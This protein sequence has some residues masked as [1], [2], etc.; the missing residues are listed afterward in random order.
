MAVDRRA[1]ASVFVLVGSLLAGPAAGAHQSAVVV[2]APACR[3]ELYPLTVKEVRARAD[4]RNA[5]L[6]ALSPHV[7]YADLAGQSR[8]EHAADPRTPLAFRQMSSGGLSAVAAPPASSPDPITLGLIEERYSFVQHVK[9]FWAG[10]E[11]TTAVYVSLPGAKI[12]S[13]GDYLIG[14][15]NKAVV[16]FLHGGATATSSGKAGVNIGEKMAPRGFATVAIDLF[17]HGLGT[18]DLTGLED[19]EKQINFVLTVLN[20]LIHPAVRRVGVGHSWGAQLYEYAHRHSDEAKYKN[21]DH[22]YILAP[23]V[24]ASNCGDLRV[25]ARLDAERAARL[26]SLRDQ[27]APTDKKFL[28]QWLT[29]GRDSEIGRIF[30]AATDRGYANPPLSIERQRQLKPATKIVSLGDGVTFVGYEE[31][32]R[33]AWGNLV[34]PSRYI[35]LGPGLTFDGV[36]PTGHGQFDLLDERGRF[37]VYGLI[38]DTLREITGYAPVDVDGMPNLLMGIHQNFPNLLDQP[39]GDVVPAGVTARLDK[40]REYL[41]DY[42]RIAALGGDARKSV[43]APYARAYGELMVVE[44]FARAYWNFPGFRTIIER[45]SQILFTSSVDTAEISGRK[46][47]LDKYQRA[48][49]DLRKTSAATTKKAVKTAVEELAVRLDL[50]ASFDT[51]RATEELNFPPLTD[52]RRAAL[53][54]LTKRAEDL[55]NEGDRSAEPQFKAD[56]E[57][58]ASRYETTLSALDVT[59]ATYAQARKTFGTGKNLDR[60]QNQLRVN[61]EH[62]HKD[63]QEAIKAREDRI[64]AREDAVLIPLAKRAGVANLTTARRELEANRSHDRR[65]A[66]VNF[67]TQKP[68]VVREVEA[69]ANDRLAEELAAV[70]R[71]AGADELSDFA[72]LQA[73]NDKLMRLA[74]APEGAGLD[75]LVAQIEAA[76]HARDLALKG[77]PGQPHLEA[78]N[79]EVESLR[80]ERLDAIAGWQ[81]LWDQNLFGSELT[82]Q[83]ASHL[84]ALET[85]YRQT[86]DRYIDIV[87]SRD[88]ELQLADLWNMDTILNT[89]PEVRDALVA[90]QSA[91]REYFTERAQLDEA[92]VAEALAG[93]LQPHAG[94]S[95]DL[96]H[97]A[98]RTALDAV[99]EAKKIWGPHPLH[100]PAA[101]DDSLTTKLLTKENQL[102]VR[103]RELA[104]Q[105]QRFD[106]LRATYVE[107]MRE[108]GYRVPNDVLSIRFADYFNSATCLSELLRRMD[109]EPRLYLALEKKLTEWEA[110]MKLLRTEHNRAKDS[111]GY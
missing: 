64:T 38:E 87:T 35:E 36:R 81:L 83:L 6:R 33:K 54:E 82:D 72:V 5:E 4:R 106:E 57:R 109:L 40:L 65:L 89:P 11:R 22:F 73:E 41:R 59:L 45:G 20:Q 71:P 103:R 23:P 44:Q 7:D 84:K 107:Q 16:A 85:H 17:G 43:E 3:A 39:N 58:L 28:D 48:L 88:L 29:N 2:E 91:K 86:Y 37:L 69:A 111:P 95:P 8:I 75:D 12:R 19:A 56:L 76:R 30:C 53:N 90:Y 101:T 70:P 68:I 80:H 62:L 49:N 61:L 92:R 104:E 42:D 63:V 93:N 24:D 14:P 100:A 26:P 34:A 18:K 108:R 78:L 9:T 66:L 27:I 67:I 32:A 102:E 99:T 46:K 52:E 25:K 98:T 10:R 15:E 110:L 74:L 31:S 13:A 55:R 79:K 77:S 51:D 60:E 47:D 1:Y 21:F 50:P 105:N 96:V 94:L 97:V